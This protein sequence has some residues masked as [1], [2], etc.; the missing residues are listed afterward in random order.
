MLAVDYFGKEGYNIIQIIII[1][2]M[3]EAIV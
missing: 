3:K 2:I 1:E